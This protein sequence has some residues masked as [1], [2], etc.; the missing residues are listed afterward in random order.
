MFEMALKNL[1]TST[2]FMWCSIIRGKGR[3]YSTVERSLES[4]LH[5]N[6]R[7]RAVCSVSSGQVQCGVGT[8]HI[9]WGYE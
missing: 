4:S 8:F 5:F 6:M 9:L 1:E 3:F 7:C 2:V